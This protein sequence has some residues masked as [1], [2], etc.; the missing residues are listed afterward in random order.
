[1]GH[2]WLYKMGGFQP[3]RQCDCCG[4]FQDFNG[5]F[6]S[7]NIHYINQNFKITQKEIDAIEKNYKQEHGIID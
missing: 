3:Q 5:I 7:G 4:L 6:W 2:V 1:M